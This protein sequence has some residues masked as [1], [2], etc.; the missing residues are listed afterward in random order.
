MKAGSPRWQFASRVSFPVLQISIRTQHRSVLPYWFIL[1]RLT[2]WG[3]PRARPSG[4]EPPAGDL[5]SRVSFPVLQISIR[6][7][8]RSVLPYWFI[9]PRLTIWGLPRARPSV[10]KYSAEKTGTSPLIMVRSETAAGAPR[11]LLLH[12]SVCMI[13]LML[14][15]DNA[16]P[17]HHLKKKEE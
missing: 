11:L 8:H 15:Q 12:Q 2:I 14:L 4:G 3:L 9:L 17:V 7:Q 6:T 13:G 1:P 5:A 16:T 10:P